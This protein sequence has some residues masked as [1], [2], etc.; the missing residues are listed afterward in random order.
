M[1]FDIRKTAGRKHLG[2]A[3][4]GAF[5]NLG[6]KHAAL[7]KMFSRL[8]NKTARNLKTVAPAVKRDKRLVPAVAEQSLCLGAWNIRRV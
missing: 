3:A 5:V 2:H 1:N 6:K 4:G 8:R 7:H